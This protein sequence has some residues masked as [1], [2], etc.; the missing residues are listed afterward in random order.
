M[1]KVG[2]IVREHLWHI[3]ITTK[4]VNYYHEHLYF[5]TGNLS[6][7][8]AQFWPK[9]LGPEFHWVDFLHMPLT[10]CDNHVI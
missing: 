7:P 5:G 8:A 9:G 6:N 1:Y 10:L 2:K 4:V 3:L